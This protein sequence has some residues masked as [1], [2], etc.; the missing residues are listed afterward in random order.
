MLWTIG[1]DFWIWMVDVAV[2][3]IMRFVVLVATMV[4]LTQQG[5]MYFTSQSVELSILKPS[6]HDM[7]DASNLFLTCAP[8]SELRHV[9][10]LN[11]RLLALTK[12]LRGCLSVR[13]EKHISRIECIPECAR[14]RSI[15][16]VRHNFTIPTTRFTARSTGD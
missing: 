5:L 13:H 7:H 16:I 10:N 11:I 1:F 3:G 9:T 15:T 2:G 4:V 14:C 8:Q 6:G 12:H